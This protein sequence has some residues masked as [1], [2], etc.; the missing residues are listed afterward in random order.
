M[1]QKTNLNIGPYYDDF[2]KEKNY[3]R[4][5]FKPG[6]PV[7][8]RELTTL[9]SN[10]QNQIE[11][12]GTHLFKEGSMVIPGSI[13]YD[14]N[15][16]AVKINDQHLGIDVSV[17]IKD[18]VGKKIRGQQSN[19]TAVIDNYL[20]AS[21]DGEVEFITLYVKYL[22]SGEDNETLQFFDDENLV[23]QENIVYGNTVIP[24]QSTVATTI[25]LDSTATGSSVGISS[26][27]YFI[28]GTFVDVSSSKIILDPYTNTPSYRVGLTIVEDIVNSKEDASLFDNAKG[29][30]NFAA[31]GADRLKI[32]TFLSKKSLDDFEDKNFIELVKIEN[33]ELKKLQN[34]SQYSEIK[35]YFAKRTYEESGDYTLDQFDIEVTN[36]L[37]DG[38]SSDGL[39]FEGQTTSQGNIPSENLMCVKVSPG[40]S[41]IRG[42]DVELLGTT[43]IDIEKP[44]DIQTVQSTLVP[45]NFGHILRVNNVLGTPYIGINEDNNY[46]TLYKRRRTSNNTQLSSTHEIGRARVYSYNL[47]D[48]PYTSNSTNWDLNLFDI[49]TYTYLTI[50]SQIPETDCPANSYIQGLSSGASGYVLESPTSNILRIL[51]TSGSFI[52]GEQISVNGSKILTRS[53]ELVESYGIQ[54]IRSVFQNSSLLG[55]SSN[56]IADVTLEKNLAPRFGISDTVTIS[57]AGT[58]TSP[59]GNF[60][61]I[62]KDSIIRYQIS[63]N[64]LETFNRVASI[65]SDEKEIQLEA[66]PSVSDVCSGSLPSAE[67]TTTIHIG[68]GK[69][70]SNDDKLYFSLPTKNISS[71]NLNNS[72][73]TVKTQIKQLSTDIEGN[74]VASIS[75]TGI[76]SAFFVPFDTERYSVTYSNG[77]VE[78]LTSDQVSV[79]NNGSNINI[80]GLS[81]NQNANITL[82]ATVEK[83]GLQHKVKNYVRGRKLVV[84]KTVV[85]ENDNVTGLTTSNYYGLRIQDREISLNVPDAAKVIGIFESL[86]GQ[87]PILDRLTFITGLNLDSSSVIGEK[88]VGDTSGAIAQLITKISS[89]SVEICYLNSLKFLPGETV[90]FKESNIRANI[91]QIEVGKYL[92]L[93]DSFTL[94]NGQ[95]QQYYDYSRILRNSFSRMPSRRLLVVFDYYEIP[96]NDRGDLYTTNSYPF[97]MYGDETLQFSGLRNSDIL[98]FRPRVSE[99]NSINTSPFTF[100]ARNFGNSSQNNSTLVIASNET[101]VLGYSYYLPRTDKVVL[102]KLGELSVIKG[103]SSTNPT[104]PTNIEEAIT[105]ALIKLPPYLYKPTD[106]TII[107]IDNKRYTMREIGQ[108]KDRVEKLEIQTSLSLLELSTKTLQ[109]QDADGLSRF[110]TGFFADPFEN[111]LLIDIE[112]PDVKCDVDTEKSE[113]TTPIDFYTIKPEIALSSSLNPETADFTQDLSLLDSNVKKTGDLITLSY[114]EVGWLE[115]P[116]A[117]RVE[118]VNP[119]NMILWVGRVTLSPS[120]DSWVRT[121][122]LNNG[123]RTILGDRNINYVE[124]ILIS[125]TPEKYIRSRNIKFSS[126]GLK[127][128]TRYYP[129]FDGNSRVDIIPKL[130]EISMTSGIFRIGE[131]VDGFIGENKVISFRLCQSNHKSGSYNFPTK[132]FTT[133][134]YDR[135]LT[136]SPTYSASSTLLNV[137]INSLSEE[138]IGRFGGYVT[139]EVILI[140]K[141][142][143]AQAKVSNIR[144]IGDIY[145][146][147]EGSIFIRD[148]LTSPPP[149]VRFLTGRRTFK[150]TS[151]PTNESNTEG[152]L[153]ISSG[154]TTYL[155]SGRLDVFRQTN[156]VVRVPPPPSPPPEPRRP[157]IDPLAQSFTVDETGAFL[158]SADLYFA[159]KDEN[160][161]V[162]IELR[163]VELGI[164]TNQLVQDF[165]VVTLEP[166]QINIS[167]D[168]SL[169]TRV[170]FPSP[171]YLQP[172][173]EYALVIL[174]PSS[175][176]YE[177]WI[178]RFGETTVKTQSLPNAESILMTRQYLGGSLFKSQNGTIWTATQ[179]ED[180]KFKIYK[181]RFVNSGVVYFYNPDLNANDSNVS[182]LTENPITTYPRKIKVGIETTTNS[183]IINTISI[184]TRVGQNDNFGTN[185]FI[186]NVGS[187]IN[188][189]SI[190]NVGAGYSN[191]TFSNVP[192]FS[193]TGS[194]EGAVANLQFTNNK[195]ASVVSIV[196]S[197]TGY[198]QGDILG[199][200]TSSVIKGTNGYITVSS[201]DGI[202]TLYLTNVQGEQ[203]TEGNELVRYAEN[204]SLIISPAV[205][206]GTSSVINSLY[207]GNVISIENYSH[208]MHSDTNI[209][210]LEDISPDTF[211]TVL[212]QPLSSD[213]TVISVASTLPFSTFEG[214]SSPTGYLKVNNEIIFYSSIGEGILGIGQRGIDGSSIR[215][216]EKNSIVYKYELNGIS[217]TRINTTHNLPNNAYLKSLRDID[218]FHLEINR[219]PR[220]GGNQ[221]LSFTTEETCGGNE[222]KTS[223]NI[224]FSSIIPQVNVITPGQ[225]TRVITQLRTVSGTSCAGN[226][227]SFIDQGFENI[228]LGQNNDLPTTRLVCSR[229]N[230][231]GRLQNLPRNKSLTLSVEMQSNDSNLSP[232]IDTSN[233]SLVFGRYKLN[234]P[235]S[236]YVYDNR[237]NLIK[238]DPHSGIY[239]SK[240]IDLSQPASSLKVYL[241][242]YRDFSSD[243]RVLYRLF[244]PDS[245]NITQTYNLFPGYDNLVDLN[246]DGFGDI[247]IDPFQNTGNPDAFVRS[248]LEG[249]FLEYQYSIDNLEQFTGF[250]IKVVLSGTNEARPPK[251]KDIRVIA[252]A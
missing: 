58:V 116:F 226:E 194:G 110:K 208:G 99:F 240:K 241:T 60:S 92:N 151:S 219:S 150:L 33:G 222:V 132:F 40:K 159:S 104:E 94:D 35:D 171:I 145:G 67:I 34:K 29:F 31:P 21:E 176:N 126:V 122:Y 86:D 181:C 174:S 7:Q 221:Q 227:I 232:V 74:L 129:F 90:T 251:F 212:T 248:S 231:I 52:Q 178:G 152:S 234:N 156:V 186:E 134:P 115:Q 36:S 135:S 82:N 43:V 214:V 190:F 65:S 133:N 201:I 62:K 225:S 113:L 183:S 103:V 180:L 42:Y 3:Y 13:T 220:S 102:N 39:Y 144:L 17:Y 38:I 170:T 143:L 142:S 136:I 51:Q 16:Y 44:R 4:V 147:V 138:M 239:I 46:V 72:S 164:P 172:N 207:E 95:R 230:E 120:S 108:I 233:I 5:L 229:V 195:L 179:N 27:V 244:K 10:L 18:L 89:T 1:P 37:N 247:V 111:T 125:R 189:T 236:N 193:V 80:K 98:D 149:S 64:S 148:P 217:L 71:V 112:N 153:L 75:N 169:A 32:S 185:G 79:T 70:I 15:Y 105:L 48:S 146:Y 165:A 203:I 107:L 167:D 61:G 101:S 200:T 252:L 211:P 88:I 184:G 119:F 63:G 237:V 73:L 206:R 141:T 249:E 224:Q 124:N 139:G 49:Q 128:F 238:D 78:N 213:S 14:S 28:R 91:Q 198:S 97:D 85:K 235:I 204:G 57:P 127:P 155:T 130:L 59:G 68:S 182:T 24:N 196:S 20:L 56:F 81:I 76:T 26:G 45:F 22:N 166:S 187:S 25:S 12:F 19:V 6:F 197:G 118:N 168:A 243:F 117:T 216:H 215:S 41:Y 83:V 2:D 218:T 191:G 223:K 96:A 242:A 131:T 160:E 9:Q 66:V 8:A 30:S 161:N 123:T 175:N 205:L 202:D 87:D 157:P 140:G 77:T 163:T 245:D 121:V 158:S 23:S 210:K 209:V 246:G 192:L 137:D 47:T 11:S 106:A 54:D 188:T 114:D 53:I 250:S 93:T 69:I 55:L 177:M 154:E 199:I 84:N 228:E 100:S 162:T 109:I 50:N 173:T